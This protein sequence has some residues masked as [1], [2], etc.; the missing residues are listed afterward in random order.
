MDENRRELIR[1]FREAYSLRIKEKYKAVEFRKVLEGLIKYL[2]GYSLD[3]KEN[4]SPLIKSL[5]YNTRVNTLKVQTGI[6][7]L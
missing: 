7:I 4:I 3:S 1:L 5:K 2:N 6:E